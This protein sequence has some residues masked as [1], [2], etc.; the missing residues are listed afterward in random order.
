MILCIG[1]LLVIFFCFG[2]FGWGRRMPLS[3]RRPMRRFFRPAPPPP[4][5]MHG[6]AG[7]MPGRRP[8]HG[9]GRRKPGPGH[10]GHRLFNVFESLDNGS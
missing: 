9:H 2:L 8:P 7:P 5:T 6:P 4:P 3:P 1:I 10:H